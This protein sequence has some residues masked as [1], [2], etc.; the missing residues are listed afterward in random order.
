MSINII[1]DGTFADFEWENSPIMFNNIACN[2][3]HSTLLQCFDSDSIGVYDCGRNNTAGVICELPTL[4]NIK[5]LLPIT[6]SVSL[7][8]SA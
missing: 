7:H 8:H 6:T 5:T 4:D 2:E 1:L 3:A